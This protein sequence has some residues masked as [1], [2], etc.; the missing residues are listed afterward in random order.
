M[1]QP[2]T[3]EEAYAGG[4]QCLPCSLNKLI[5]ISTKGQWATINGDCHLQKTGQSPSTLTCPCQNHLTYRAMTE[6]VTRV[7]L[8][9]QANTIEK[10]VKRL[11]I[12]SL[13]NQVAKL[14]RHINGQ[15]RDNRK[16]K[17]L[18]TGGAM[19]ADTVMTAAG[20]DTPS[21]VSK[22]D[23]LEPVRLLKELLRPAHKIAAQIVRTNTIT[24]PT[25]ITGRPGLALTRDALASQY[26][27]KRDFASFFNGTLQRS[28]HIKNTLQELDNFLQ[29]ASMQ[30][31][32]QTNNARSMYG[33]HDVMRF[34]RDQLPENTNTLMV[35]ADEGSQVS[36][37]AIYPIQEEAQTI[38]ITAIPVP[39]WI[40]NDLTEPD[41]PMT[42]T[43]FDPSGFHTNRHQ[44][45]TSRCLMQLSEG[46]IHPSGC[47][48]DHPNKPIQEISTL[49][50]RDNSTIYR[51]MRLAMPGPGH[52]ILRL[53]CG[54]T[55]RFLE[56]NTISVLLLGPTCYLR[57][58]MGNLLSGP[59][60]TT[61]PIHLEEGFKILYN[62]DIDINN[63]HITKEVTHNALMAFLLLAVVI[64]GIDR[65]YQACTN[66]SC[67]SKD[68]MSSTYRRAPRVEIHPEAASPTHSLMAEENF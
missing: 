15:S 19:L 39:T 56:L 17:A 9:A 50:V 12:R 48:T 63:V 34:K 66:S 43:Q 21:A 30:K 7:N 32:Y 57:D 62:M 54:R 22:L 65:I 25:G 40:G 67:R 58:A 16:L 36:R 3:E 29:E 38:E 51:V 8:K 6:E 20:W 28:S 24:T 44:S 41:L 53:S 31:D 49:V 5:S 64:L 2:A 13:G 46:T 4:Q 11:N 33:I 23:A 35:T 26:S 68:N 55:P 14:L 60:G 52:T 18:L 47:H 42:T 1:F 27:P 45:T 61:P 10:P 37:I 59:L